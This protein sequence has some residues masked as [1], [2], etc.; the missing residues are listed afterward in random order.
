MRRHHLNLW[1]LWLLP[2]LIA[3]LCVPGGFMLSMTTAGIDITLC[4]ATAALPLPSGMYEG[5]G[6]HAGMDHSS[7]ADHLTKGGTPHQQHAKAQCAFA[8]AATATPNAVTATVYE[9]RRLTERVPVLQVDPSWA[10]PATRIDRIRGP[11][12]A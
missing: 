9:L 3:R 10:S 6:A 8:L 12:L 2:L 1:T 4:P 11:P 7:H 5:H